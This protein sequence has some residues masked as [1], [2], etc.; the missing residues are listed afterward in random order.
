MATTDRG[1]YYTDGG[2]DGDVADLNV[3]TKAIADSTEA[4]LDALDGLKVPVS[5]YNAADV[6]AK[7]K[8]VD[9]AG[10]GL[11][12]DML[13]GVSSAGFATAA[14]GTKA[15][16]SLQRSGGV[17]TG[18]LNMD[19]KYVLNIGQSGAAND[20]ATVGQ[21]NA[22]AGTSLQCS[23]GVMPGDLKMGGKYV[24]NIGQS[25]GANEAAT[26]GQVNAVAA[27]HI[28]GVKTGTSNAAGYLSIYD[29]PASPTGNWA[30][31]ANAVRSDTG[32]VLSVSGVPLSATQVTFTVYSGATPFQGAVNIF[33]QAVAY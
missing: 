16:A 14:Q 29:F 24:L 3:I 8:T 27:G 26:V 20:A 28:A 9:G 5:S 25:G 2:N 15:D 18:D 19:G 7:I 21:V 12:A 13:D 33:W 22:V 31:V 32:A 4:A 17:M 6:L 23:G 1:I 30:V 10:S 11:D